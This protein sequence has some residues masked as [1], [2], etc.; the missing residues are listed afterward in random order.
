MQ[1]V[2]TKELAKLLGTLSSTALAILPAPL[3]MRYLQRQQIF[4]LCLKRD[5]I[6]KVALVHST[7]RS[8]CMDGRWISNKLDTPKSIHL[9]AFCSYRE[10]ASQSN[11]G[12]LYVDH[13]NTRVTFPTMVN[14]VIGN[15]YTRSNFRF[16]ISKSFDR[17]KPEP[18]PTVSGKIILQKAYQT[19]QLT[20]LKVAEAWT[21]CIITKQCGKSGVAFIKNW[22]RYCRFKLCVRIFI[23]FSFRR[24]NV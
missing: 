5:Y 15:V 24:T 17:P 14:P 7:S 19:K 21:H 18:T 16:P 13:N 12:Q 2:S 6:T 1:E 9:P 11:E 8:T 20:C 23:Q 4:S 3:Y 22:S 10:G